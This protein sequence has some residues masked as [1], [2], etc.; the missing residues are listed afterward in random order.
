MNEGSLLV[1][2]IPSSNRT[3][4]SR[5]RRLVEE[6]MGSLQAHYAMAC[7]NQG[8]CRSLL[9]VVDG[10]VGVSLFYSIKLEPEH[11]LGV[12]Y[13]VVVK[14]EFRG[15]SIGRVLV[16]STEHVLEDDGVDAVVATTRAD[17]QHSRRLFGSLGYTEIP[18]QSIEEKYGE[19]FT[20]LTCSYE[21]DVVLA[22]RFKADVSDLIA[23]L[24]IK[25]NEEKIEELWRTLCYVPWKQAR[26]YSQ[27][28]S[29]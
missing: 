21:D 4:S 5:V 26:L 1:V 3:Y 28:R 20:K 6:G 10:P 17:N 8:L 16:L 14:R 15:E 23:V 7:F 18:L 29:S 25:S 9:A 27:S 13:Y 2:E 11:T 19:M 22:K 24:G 12:I